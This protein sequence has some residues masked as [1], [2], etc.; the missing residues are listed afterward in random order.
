MPWMRTVALANLSR[1]PRRYPEAG[2]NQRG[3][4]SGE[5]GLDISNKVLFREPIR[6]GRWRPS[7]FRFS[8]TTLCIA[9]FAASLGAVGSEP[10]Y[11][12]DLPK[13]FGCYKCG[14]LKA[15]HVLASDF[16]PTAPTEPGWP[17]SPL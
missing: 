15:M 6:L 17:C 13:A 8:V 12:A 1:V 9:L 4:Y 16:L 3:R 14:T 2:R 5:F 11:V 7:G 10:S